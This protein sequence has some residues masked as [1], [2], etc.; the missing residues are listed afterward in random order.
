MHSGQGPDAFCQ[1]QPWLVGTSVAVLVVKMAKH[2]SISQQSAATLRSSH[3][4]LHFPTDLDLLNSWP[5]ER[6]E[7]RGGLPL[8]SWSV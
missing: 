6:W 3:V 4:D 1:A 5:T 7:R 2:T 8:Q